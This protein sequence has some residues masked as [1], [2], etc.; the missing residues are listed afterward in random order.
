MACQIYT[1]Q[2]GD[3]CQSI[4]NSSGISFTQFNSWNPSINS[5]CTN[6]IA[7][8]QVCVGLPGTA[9]NGTTIIGATVTQTAVYATATVSPPSNV[10]RGTT[11][12]CGKYYTVQTGDDCSLIA[13]NKTISIGLFESIN[14]SINSDCTNLSPGLAYCVFPTSDWNANTTSG[15]TTST[16]VIA[17]APTPNGTINNCFQYHTVVSGDYC[18]LLENQYGITFAQLQTWNQDLNAA[19]SN[20]ILGDAYCVQGDTSG[21]GAA[22]ASSTAPVTMTSPG[23]PTQSGI[24]AS[25]KEYYT[26]QSGD[27]CTAVESEFGV[28]FAQLYSWNPAIGSNCNYLVV[29][30]AICVL[31]PT[32]SSSAKSSASTKVATSVSSTVSIKTS[33][34]S[35]KATTSSATPGG[36]TQSGITANC[37][38]Y[39][40]VKSG[41]SCAGVESTFSISFAQ[42]YA[43]NPAIGSNCQYLVVG[44]AVCVSGPQATSTTAAKVSSSST[45]TK[46]APPGPTQSGTAANCNKYYVVQSGDSC[47]GVESKYSITFNQLYG[48]NPSIGS[49]C[50]YLGV[51]NAYCVGVSS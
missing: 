8:Q 4:T 2:S 43:W 3:T 44:D 22:A 51:G 21:N 39:Y 30:D 34:S 41:D 19:C 13:L 27:S 35:V 14:P 6:L 36:P 10:A 7:G 29:G 9:Y 16:Y 5:F 37:K 17:P 49:N 20:L 26:V 33:S 25:C 47:A 40:T 32:V 45:S 1:V 38:Q 28:T 24:T 12:F 31:G 42:L 23:G 11:S 18:G 50:Q 48:W 46:V 15:N